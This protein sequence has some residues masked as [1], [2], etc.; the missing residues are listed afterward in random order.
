[1]QGPLYMEGSLNLEVSEF[2]MTSDT[3]WDKHWAVTSWGSAAYPWGCQSSM[4]SPY[5]E[6]RIATLSQ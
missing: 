6:I 4:F 3:L 5:R 1:M 2:E